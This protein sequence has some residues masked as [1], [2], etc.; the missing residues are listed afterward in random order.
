MSPETQ[1][2]SH[3]KSS[4]YAENHHNTLWDQSEPIKIHWIL[5]TDF[6]VSVIV[7]NAHFQ[8]LKNH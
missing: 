4:V 7:L 8:N 1:K 2:A 5:S 6:R 3:L